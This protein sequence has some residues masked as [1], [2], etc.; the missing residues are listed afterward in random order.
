MNVL[1]QFWETESIGIKSI[2]FEKRN[3]KKFL[4]DIRIT[5][6]R[7]EVGL[8]WK[9]KWSAI[10]YDYDLCHN[11]LRLPHRKLRKQPDIMAEYDK[12]IEEQLATGIVEKGSEREKNKEENGV[13]YLTME[14]FI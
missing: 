13:H 3:E 6:E 10:D 8:P 5:D 11:R 9:S 4:P 12:R 2:A 1:K 14:S 7:Y